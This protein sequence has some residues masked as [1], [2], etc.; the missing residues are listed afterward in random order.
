[1]IK[2]K[3]RDLEAVNANLNKKSGEIKQQLREHIDI[4]EEKY[5]ELRAMS[6]DTLTVKNLIAVSRSW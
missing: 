4:D 3:L 1:M 2:V 5:Y 6:E